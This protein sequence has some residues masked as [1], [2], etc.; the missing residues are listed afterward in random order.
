MLT[1]YQEQ[2]PTVIASRSASPPSDT[3]ARAMLESTG[4]NPLYIEEVVRASAADGTTRQ[5]VRESEHLPIGVPE[6]LQPIFAQIVDRLGRECGTLFA[7]GEYPE[8]WVLDGWA[9]NELYVVRAVLAFN[10][11]FRIEFG[12]QY[13]L[14]H[15]RNVIREAFP[16]MNEERYAH[17]GGGSLWIRRIA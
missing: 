15:H 2:I 13:M 1:F 14:K 17:P 9:W 6:S 8:A 3:E 7:P 5:A 12:A 10:S 16:G 11:A 4:G